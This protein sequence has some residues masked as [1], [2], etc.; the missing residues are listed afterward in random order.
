MLGFS[1]AKINLGLRILNK[2]PDG[3]HNI[4]SV[5]VPIPW[6]DAIEIT[7]PAGIQK[8]VFKFYGI[9]I[10]GLNENNNLI[11]TIVLLSEMYGIN[12]PPL[13]VNVLKNL[14]AGAG[15]GGGS[16]NATAFLNLLDEM[17]GLGLSFGQKSDLL[18]RVG[19]DCP[20]FLHNKPCLV[21]GTGDIIIPFDFERLK[22]YYIVCIWPGIHSDTAFA[23]KNCRPKGSDD[24]LKE[25]LLLHPVHEWKNLIFNDFEDVLFPKYPELAEIKNLLY[26]KGALY[27]S[28]SGSG[29]TI[30]GIFSSD[31]SKFLKIKQDKIRIFTGKI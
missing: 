4:R 9:D 12:F 8:H 26:E 6:H 22:G 11:K 20:F 24:N 16:S 5:F 29:S 2:R 19:A 30:Y 14:P 10:P 27:A 25:I 17:F 1:N 7:Q 28:M 3:Y 15:L 23:Y 13:K 31:P 18:S 21:E